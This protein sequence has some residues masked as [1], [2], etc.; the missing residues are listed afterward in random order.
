MANERFWETKEL[1][2]LNHEE[3]ESLCD[4]CAQCCRLKFEDEGTGQLAI[5]TLVCRLLDID[6]CRCKHY[7]ERHSFVPECVQLT[8]DNV[9]ELDWLPNT[10]GYRRVAEG[11][12]LEDWHPLISGSFDSVKKAGIGVSQLAV[13]EAQ[14]HPDD[15]IDHVLK[16]VTPQSNGK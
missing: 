12:P 1:H 2:E 13:S 4:G 8:P 3:W 7:E 16:W 14:V 6:E 15:I 5:T 11:K 9:K 10:C